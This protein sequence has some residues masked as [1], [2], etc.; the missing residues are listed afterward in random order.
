[1]W[2][3][4]YLFS[5]GK[6]NRV[7]QPPVKREVVD[8]EPCH[9]TPPDADVADK[10]KK[11]VGVGPGA[12]D[13]EVALGRGLFE[14]LSRPADWN[15]GGNTKMCP[16]FTKMNLDKLLEG[17]VYTWKHIFTDEKDQVVILRPGSENFIQIVGF[18]LNLKNEIA[19]DK[20][21]KQK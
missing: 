11:K 19:L 13:K 16:V 3:Q 8:F 5:V 7:D 21:V 12:V 1:M 15:T 18:A 14:A 2:L 6:T 20:K 4:I 9:N 10:K 17:L